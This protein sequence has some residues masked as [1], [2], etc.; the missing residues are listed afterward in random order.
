MGY[1]QLLDNTRRKAK[2]ACTPDSVQHVSVPWRSF[3]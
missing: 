1:G 2:P 3:L